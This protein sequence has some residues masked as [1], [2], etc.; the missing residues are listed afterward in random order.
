[1]SCSPGWSQASFPPA[2]TFQVLIPGLHCHTWRFACSY[3]L[4][5]PDFMFLCWL[6]SI[7]LYAEIATSNLSWVL[8]YVIKNIFFS[9]L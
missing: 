1:M 3:I 8:T 5:D 9:C 2:T 7:L 4:A 6:L